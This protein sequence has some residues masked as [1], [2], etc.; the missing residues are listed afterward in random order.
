MHTEQEQNAV[1]LI[2]ALAEPVTHTHTKTGQARA[3]LTVAGTRETRASTGRPRTITWRHRVSLISDATRTLENIEPGDV[4]HVSGSLRSRAV[5]Q[6]DGRRRHTVE[7]YARSVEPTHHPGRVTRDDRGRHH[8]TEAFNKVV[9]EGHLARVMQL[10][11]TDAGVALALNALVN[12]NPNPRDP[13]KPRTTYIPINLWGDLAE[14]H[15]HHHP[16][17]RLHIEGLLL[18]RPVTDPQGAITYRAV[19]EATDAHLLPRT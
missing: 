6:E 10:R 4:I 19:V 18:R 8:L 12:T 5:T 16:G 15:A 17:T 1:T 2:G 14:E 3:L 7:V 11:Y 13:A 9:I